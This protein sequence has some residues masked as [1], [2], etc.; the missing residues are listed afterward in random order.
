MRPSCSQ[1]ADIGAREGHEPL[2]DVL[3]VLNQAA[4]HLAA[5]TGAALTAGLDWLAVN[6]DEPFERVRDA[7]LA[8]LGLP[9]RG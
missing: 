2:S 3:G 7:V 9:V 5:I 6:P 4:L 1:L 8:S